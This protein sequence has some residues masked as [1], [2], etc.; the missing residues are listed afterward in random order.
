MSVSVI[1]RVTCDASVSR[2]GSKLKKKCGSHGEFEAANIVYAKRAAEDAGW[3]FVL[4]FTKDH[5]LCPECGPAIVPQYYT[6]VSR[7]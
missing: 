1:V 5:I 3:R 4:H 7:G 2:P 6:K